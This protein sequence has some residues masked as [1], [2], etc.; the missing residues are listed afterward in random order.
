[1]DRPGPRRGAGLDEVLEHFGVKGMRWGV[2]RSNP[3][4]SAP[5]S[6]DAHRLHEIKTTASKGGGTRVLSNK[7]LQDAITRMNLERQYKALSPN[8][9]QQVLQF[10]GKTLLGIGKQEATKLAA[11][12]AAKQIANLLKR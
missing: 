5:S 3:S 2:R 12:V 9:K 6:T 11:E 10:V 8:K 1:M 4:S 7:D